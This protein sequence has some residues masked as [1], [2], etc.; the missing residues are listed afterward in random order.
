MIP[1]LTKLEIEPNRFDERNL[2]I[3]CEKVIK[4]LEIL[5]EKFHSDNDFRGMIFV[6]TRNGADELLEIIN[7]SFVAG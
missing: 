4:L 1:L 5:Y 6:K 3:T 7:K 2:P